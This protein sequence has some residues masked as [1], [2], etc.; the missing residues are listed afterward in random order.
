M[1]YIS[2]NM[3]AKQH[4]IDVYQVKQYLIYL[5]INIVQNNN[6]DCI[7]TKSIQQFKQFLSTYSS[8]EITY[9]I[10]HKITP[11]FEGI[12]RLSLRKKY[13]LTEKQFETKCKLANLQSKYVYSLEEYK[14][15]DNFVKLK[16]NKTEQK[17]LVYTQ[18]GYIPLRTILKDFGEQ[19][20]FC[21]NTGLAILDYLNI[22]IYKPLHQLSFLTNEQKQKL[23][24]FLKSFDNA[25]D[26]KQF[27]TKET[28]IKKYGV[29]NYAKLDN[30]KDKISEI[31]KQNTEQRMK[32]IKE[33]NIK[34]YGVP[35][36]FLSKTLMKNSVDKMLDTKIKNGTLSSHYV[37]QYDNL[38]FDSSWELYYYIY[39]KEILN[40]CIEKGKTFEYNFEGKKH[41]YKCDFLVNGQNVE[42]KGN[43]YIDTDGN[44]YFP[45]VNQTK[46]DA[47][48]LQKQWDKKNQCMK[49]NNVKV[50]SGNEM[51]EII[52]IVD[53]KYTSDY[54]KLFRKDAEF[55]YS[56][57]NFSDNSDIGLIRYFHKSIFTAN[58]HNKL[59]PFDAWQNKEL[60]K[61]SALNRLKYVGRCKP[62]DV[63]QGFTIAKIASKVSVFRPKLAE[64]LIKTYCT[65][66]KIFDPFS[67]FSGR[68]IGSANCNKTYFGQDINKEHIKESKQ[69]IEYKKYKNCEVVVQD[70]LADN[71]KIL[72]D[73]TLFTCPP[74]GNKEHWGEEKTELLCDD[75]ITVCLDKYKCKEY[76]FVVDN[77]TK[78]KE[79]VVEYLTNKSHFGTNKECVVYI[80]N[81]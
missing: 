80:G 13:N 56:N 22:S 47:C 72:S 26:R 70:V 45:Y 41:Y 51:L 4:K 65:T 7:N 18:V 63:V 40:N 77:T 57:Q 24:T 21:Y 74:Y 64:K 8:S 58:K 27:L 79:F 61:K 69:I 12:L 15:F 33:T 38:T 71:K 50:V 78:Y 23:E 5:N 28:C 75:W 32:K 43:Q 17:E 39:N 48:K 60:V 76:I 37:Y 52:K 35:Y 6:I 55:P 67:G 49:D 14:L 11:F 1:D 34:K 2:V 36:T 3:L 68:L 19:Y 31:N 59:S 44:L 53:K 73:Y 29:D 81:I 9:I 42:V 46:V 10:K 20:N 66:D 54:V 62:S 16:L 30:Y 25:S